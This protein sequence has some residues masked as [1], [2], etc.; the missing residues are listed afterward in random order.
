MKTTKGLFYCLVLFLFTNC[1]SNEVEIE[2]QLDL[3]NSSISGIYNIQSLTVSKEISTQVSIFTYEL[4]ANEESVG[5][6]FQVEL[7]IN[8]NGTYEI[9][10]AYILKTTRTPISSSANTVNIQETVFIEYKGSYTID[11]VNNNINFSGNL[12]ENLDG[13]FFVESQNETSFGLYKEN[14]S[15]S[16]SGDLIDAKTFVLFVK[17]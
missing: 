8:E 10:G 16:L 13:S 3:S 2:P 5:E 17:K 9:D 15:E 4:I 1:S 6:N 11:K 7:I 14:S 12:L